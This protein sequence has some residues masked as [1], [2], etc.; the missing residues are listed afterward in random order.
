MG[1]LGWKFG[2]FLIFG[3]WKFRE[4][5]IGFLKFLEIE[6]F[7]ELKNWRFFNFW[8]LGIARVLI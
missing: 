1:F 5:E 7:W 2:V 3:D 8:K 6:I 4:F